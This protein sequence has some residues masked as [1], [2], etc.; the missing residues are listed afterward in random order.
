MGAS[1]QVLFTLPIKAQSAFQCNPTGDGN[2]Q[3]LPTFRN[4]DGT[5]LKALLNER[6]NASGLW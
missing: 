1:A 5:K 2:F 4:S 3:V 6:Q